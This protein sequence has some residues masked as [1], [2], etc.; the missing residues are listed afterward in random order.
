M[1]NQNA[2]EGAE[3]FIIQLTYDNGTFFRNE[4][5]PGGVSERRVSDLIPGTTYSVLLFAMN[6]D[7][8]ATVGPISF[9]TTP[10]SKWLLHVLTHLLT[11]S[12]TVCILRL[13]IFWLTLYKMCI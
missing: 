11:F 6:A 8:V 3:T 5:F 10:G 1:T 7:G 9:S 13:K 4:T 2:D 12:V